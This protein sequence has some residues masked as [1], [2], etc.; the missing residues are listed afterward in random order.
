VSKST[1]IDVCQDHS[2][3]VFSLQWRQRPHQPQLIPHWP[4][5]AGE[6]GVGVGEGAGV[7]QPSMSVLGSLQHIGVFL[8]CLR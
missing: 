1:Y 6:G 5:E 7:G 8:A 3:T 2:V 4:G